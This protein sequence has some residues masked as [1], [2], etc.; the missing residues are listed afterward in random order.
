MAAAAAREE[1][2]LY[3][4]RLPERN[5]H[6][7]AL[8]AALLL[9]PAGMA[10]EYYQQIT[11][12][13]ARRILDEEQSM[14]R[15]VRA[16]DRSRHTV[17][18][19]TIAPG[20]IMELSPLLSGHFSELTVSTE[21]RDEETLLEGLQQGTYQMVILNRRAEDTA[22]RCHP[23]GSERLFVRLSPNHALANREN[24][25]FSDLNGERFL[26]VKEV[27]FW[28]GIV[29]RHMPDSRFLLQD[30]TA[31]LSELILASAL[32]SFATDLTLRIYGRSENTVYLP[33]VD[34]AALTHY[35]CCCKAGDE[36]KYLTW[37]QMLERRY[38]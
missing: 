19:G 23:C 11:Q 9:L 14:I 8:L 35:Y 4:D 2:P 15:Q 13:E 3:S 7:R 26:M 22:L 10:E 5:R 37:F 38:K 28:D 6:G 32:P 34:D 25:R 29:R 24:V 20:P 12:E 17:N 36:M 30:D 21:V 16:L 33:I 1:K 31:A 27:G 18:I